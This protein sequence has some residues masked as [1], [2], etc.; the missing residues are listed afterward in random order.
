[1][2]RTNFNIVHTE[3][4]GNNNFNHISLIFL[5]KNK[6]FACENQFGVSANFG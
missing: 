4:L 6:P 5:L 2:E 1:M 3:S